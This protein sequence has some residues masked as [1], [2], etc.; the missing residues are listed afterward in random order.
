MNKLSTVS[1]SE[2]EVLLLLTARESIRSMVNYGSLMILEEEPGYC[3][4]R[5]HEATQAE[6][7]NIRLLDFLSPV[8]HLSGNP[9]LLNAL[10]SICKAPTLISDSHIEYLKDAA[11]AMSTWLHKTVEFEKIWLPAINLELTLSMKRFEFLRICEYRQAS[12]FPLKPSD[13]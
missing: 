12:C 8:K 1:D 9:T 3:S 11:Q 7:F 10:H 2:R 13:C 4:I 5:P 6:L